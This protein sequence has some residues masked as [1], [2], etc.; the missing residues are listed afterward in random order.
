MEIV[1]QLTNLATQLDSLGLLKE[2]NEVD[3]IAAGFVKSAQYVGVQGYWIRNSRCW[4]NC[5]RQKRATSPS[6]SAQEVW[7]ECQQEYVDSIDKDSKTWDKYAESGKLVKTAVEGVFNKQFRTAVAAKVS[8]G[9][10]IGSAVF[11]TIDAE[12]RKTQDEFIGFASRL[13]SVANT[14]NDVEIAKQAAYLADEIIK[15]AGPWDFAKGL[16]GAIGRGVQQV[17]TGIA[18]GV[19]NYNAQGAA[20][21]MSSQLQKAYNQLNTA[22][23]SWNSA[24]QQVQTQLQGF[25][26]S[27]S[28]QVAQ[29]A[30]QAAKLMGQLSTTTKLKQQID[31][32]VTQLTQIMKG[33]EPQQAQAPATPA[34][35]PAT[36]AAGSP[37]PAPAPAPS[38]AAVSPAPE[39]PPA[40]ATPQPAPT[41][42]GATP[43][44]LPTPATA[45]TPPAKQPTTFQN[46]ALQNAA[47][48]PAFQNPAFQNAV[49]GADTTPVGPNGNPIIPPNVDTSKATT[50]GAP[51]AKPDWTRHLNTIE[52]P[53]AAAAKAA[54][55]PAA[56]PSQATLPFA[57]EITE[58]GADANGLD[59]PAV[60]AAAPPVP[61]VKP[62]KPRTRKILNTDPVTENAAVPASPEILPEQSGPA[63]VPPTPLPAGGSAVA[64]VQNAPA[65]NAPANAGVQPGAAF[66]P[67]VPGQQVVAPGRRPRP[68]G[69]A[70]ARNMG[71]NQTVTPVASANNK[72]NLS[73]TSKTTRRL[74]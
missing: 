7:Q 14:V 63:T 66:G 71:K 2:A 58:P 61:G 53:G 26:G 34:G 40:A 21:G 54:P 5:Y 31:P 38:P 13:A 25:Q 4:G 28:P 23:N 52:T 24:V 51:A 11:A 62:R 32:Y 74:F 8:A 45:T 67:T 3:A 15:I 17:G 56:A 49:E 10:D 29:R 43:P 19:R 46:P 33:I 41:P 16:G 70:A 60:P 35:S 30:Q 57:D 18:N 48:G 39:V 68:G 12:G 42:T 22:L 73:K 69:L 55:A 37:N 27:K 50:D 1:K 64:P 47:T 65:V 44:P 72:G 6:K 9:E 59:T 36:P 20:A